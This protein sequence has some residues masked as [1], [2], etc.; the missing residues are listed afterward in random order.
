MDVSIYCL[1]KG[2][3]QRN[4]YCAYCYIIVSDEKPDIVVSGSTTNS[5]LTAWGCRSTIKAIN[6]AMENFKNIDKLTLYTSNLYLFKVFNSELGIEKEIQLIADL[7]IQRHTEDVVR[8]CKFTNAKIE[9]RLINTEMQNND[10]RVK[11]CR[12]E[13]QK[14]LNGCSKMYAGEV[15]AKERKQQ[16]KQEK[17]ERRREAD[18]KQNKYSHGHK[19]K[20]KKKKT[21]K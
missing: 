7:G 17:L 8:A 5:N 14:A 4:G 20:H 11:L 18:R 15:A 2:T 19:H 3:L 9:V 6:K 1:S 12:T 13:C 21:E 10:E 16:E